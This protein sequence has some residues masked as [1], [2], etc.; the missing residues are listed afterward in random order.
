MEVQ[1]TGPAVGDT[2]AD[3]G[4]SPTSLTARRSA[5]SGLSSSKLRQQALPKAK[6]L[7]AAGA[8]RGESPISLDHVLGGNRDLSAS[9]SMRLGEAKMSG[10]RSKKN[11]PS[12]WVWIGIGA[13]PIVG[14]ALLVLVIMLQR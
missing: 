8:G 7:D 13:A 5:E 11:E 12:K 6:P 10:R 2:L 14:V 4:R 1:T 3:L 9:G